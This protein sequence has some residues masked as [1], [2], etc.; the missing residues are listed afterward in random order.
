MNIHSDFD[1]LIKMALFGDSQVGKTNMVIRFI[2]NVFNLNTPT[3]LGYDYK[4]KN[5]TIDKKRIKLQIWDTA[6]QERY[7]ALSKTVFQKVDGVMLVYDIT[8]KESFN[9]IVKWIDLIK[10]YNDNLPLILIGN[11][12][13]K[14]D[15]IIDTLEGKN[16]AKEYNMDFYETSAL[17]GENIEKVFREFSIIILNSLKN[18]ENVVS[19]NFS[20]KTDK[21]KKKKKHRCC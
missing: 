17:N 18:K 5:L 1:Y 3:T 21:T 12:T 4:S 11:K 20:I 14:D 19:E 7:M 2:D 6:G 8:E 9:N 16:L 15:R 13:D 10:E